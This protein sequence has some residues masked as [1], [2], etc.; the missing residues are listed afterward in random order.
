VA[1]RSDRRR[2]ASPSWRRPW[3]AVAIGSG[4]GGAPESRAAADDRGALRVALVQG[5]VPQSLRW[6]RVHASRVL[7][8]YAGSRARRSAAEPVELVIWPENA[9]QTSSADP[10]TVRRCARSWRARRSAARRRPRSETERHY[11]SPLPARAGGSAA[12][13]D[14]VRCCHSSRATRAQRAADAP[15]TRRAAR[16]RVSASA[17]ATSAC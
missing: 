14:K 11:N 13:Y 10:A 1:G 3:L 16:R 5:N 17:T 2:G 12:Y 8:R 4:P 9:L 7:R 6:N 15:R